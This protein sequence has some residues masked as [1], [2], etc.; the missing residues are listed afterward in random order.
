MNAKSR[1]DYSGAV[2]KQRIDLHDVISSATR[3]VDDEGLDGLAL[4]KVAA[5][6][7]VRTS[8]LYNHVDGVDGL[9]QALADQAIETSP[10]SCATQPSAAPAPRPCARSPR[11]TVASPTNTVV[12]TRAPCS[13]P[14]RRSRAYPCRTREIVRVIAR[15]L[16]A[17]GLVDDRAVHGARIVRSAMHGFVTLEATESFVNPQDRDESFAA[18]RPTSSIA[19]LET[20]V[21]E[22]MIAVLS[23]LSVAL[24]FVTAAHVATIA[25][26]GTGMSSESAAFQARSALMGVGF[27]T[28]EAEAAINHPVRRKIILW[29]MTFGNAGIITGAS[30][31]L[32]GFVNAET[33]QTIRRA[34]ILAAGLLAVLLLTR[35]E[36][37]ERLLTR[38]TAWAL[39]RWT[40]LDTRDFAQLLR[41][42]HDFGIIELHA[43]GDDWLVERPLS[44]LGLPAEG[45]VILGVHR[46]DGT[47]IG[48]P[49]G[50]TVIHTDDDV[51]AYGRLDHLR[52]LD[53]RHKGTHG[54]RAHREAV[55]EQHELVAG[56]EAERAPE[57]AGSDRE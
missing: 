56:Q 6:L 11:S 10:R 35:L 45:I 28:A 40:T 16:E 33:D 3:F 5:D 41:F 8:A 50:S 43:R 12:S 44:E 48:A 7:G 17:F 36:R 32:L 13:R 9:R 4:G 14:A 15:I 55:R 20:G 19:G 53:E 37:L 29:L 21:P 22:P 49:T 23:L 42:G 54:D 24:L 1:A 39:A 46:K 26:V 18:L 25:L 27:T 51:L 38:V 57:D 30:S 2:A 34:I 47:F 52:D 31:L